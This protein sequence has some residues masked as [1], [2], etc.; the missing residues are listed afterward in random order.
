M[1]WY[2]FYTKQALKD[3]ESVVAAG[4]GKRARELIELIKQD[5]FAT[6]PKFE[7]LVGDLRGTYSRRINIQHRLVYEL[8]PN[9]EER[10]A[11]DGKIYDGFVKILRMYEHY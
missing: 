5:P 1:T 7:K 9:T 4:L 2:V 6:P 10:P 8:I 11:P 3:K